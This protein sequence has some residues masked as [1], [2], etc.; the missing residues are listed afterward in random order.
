MFMALLLPATQDIDATVV[1]ELAFLGG[2]VSDRYDDGRRLFLRARL[3]IR[4][5]VRPKDIVEGGIAVRTVGREIEVCPYLFRQVCKNGAIMPQVAEAR[6]IGL[7]DYAASSETIEAAN[8]Q[9][10]E[11]VRACSAGEVF[12]Q[13]ARRV[14]AATT[15]EVPSDI[16]QVLHFLSMRRLLRSDLIDEIVEAFLA[17]N[18]RSAFGLMNA[19]TSVARDQEDPEIRWQLE[20]LGGGVPAMKFPHVRPDGSEA[21]LIVS[22]MRERFAVEAV[23]SSVSETLVFP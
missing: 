18:D 23:A 13:I 2:S 9:V 10:R 6:R 5:E 20:E 19:V 11:A 7:V 8:D 15:R 22:E 4:D 1:D 16:A 12:D 21:E 3:P 17:D 14:R